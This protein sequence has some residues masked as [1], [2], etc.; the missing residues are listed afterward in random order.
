MDR[1]G[2]STKA[3]ECKALNMESKDNFFF[4]KEKKKVCM[5]LCSEKG[6]KKFFKHFYY[7]KKLFFQHKTQMLNSFSE[8]EK[9]FI[10]SLVYRQG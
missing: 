7:F 8:H 5:T 10:K 9:I 3:K 1:R 6:K 4:L 2:E